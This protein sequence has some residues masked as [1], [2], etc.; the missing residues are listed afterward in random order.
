MNDDINGS[1]SDLLPFKVVCGADDGMH[2]SILSKILSLFEEKR[3][4][5]NNNITI[6]FTFIWKIF[7]QR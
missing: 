5:R 4:P 1:G 7:K 2:D 3:F 6:F